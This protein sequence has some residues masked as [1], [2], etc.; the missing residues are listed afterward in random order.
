[1]QDMHTEGHV[2]WGEKKKGENVEQKAREVETRN[3]DV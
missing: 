2:L 3:R 1:M